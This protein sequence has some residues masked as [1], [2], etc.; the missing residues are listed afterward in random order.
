MSI[1]VSDGPPSFALPSFIGL[2]QSAAEARASSYGLKIS[3]FYLPNTPQT[4][5]ITQSP[6]PGVTVRPG[7][8]ITPL[9]RLR[10]PD[11]EL[12]GA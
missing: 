10:K 2:S 3:W 5:V 7:D 9:P 11:P 12:R 6:S 1:V 8:T 4:A